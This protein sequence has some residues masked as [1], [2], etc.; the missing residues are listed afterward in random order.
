[1]GSCCCFRLCA[2]GAVAV[3]VT[4]G[5]IEWAWGEYSIV[6]SIVEV[7]EDAVETKVRCAAVL[8]FL[9]VPLWFWISVGVFQDY[10]DLLNR[11]EMVHVS[12]ITLSV[13]VRGFGAILFIAI[14]SR[15]ALV[16]GKTA[17]FVIGERWT[18]VVNKTT[19]YFALAVI[20]FAVEW[21]Y[22]SIDLLEKYE[23][24]YRRDLIRITP[25][26]IHFMY[27]KAR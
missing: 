16:T 26:R 3:L 10:I 14:F 27:V 22:H 8:S 6:N 1:M 25:T 5:I 24:V 11:E 23:Y 15:V 20:A 7:L 18:P 9:L 19:L 4:Y 17:R 2:V 13:P 21:T 12:V